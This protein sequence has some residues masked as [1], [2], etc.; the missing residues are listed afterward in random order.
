MRQ[1]RFVVDVNAGL[2]VAESLRNAGHDTI[3][4]GDLDW[5]MPDGDM[6]SLACREKR[7]ILTMDTDF[8]ELVYRLRQP[9]AVVLLLRLPGA[10]RR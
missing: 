9:H 3:F 7:I 6:L 4:A 5:Q 8:G 1:L 10:N 2:A